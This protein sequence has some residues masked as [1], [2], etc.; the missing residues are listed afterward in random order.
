MSLLEW[1]SLGLVAV[2][3]PCFRR[4]AKLALG[5]IETKK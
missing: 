5:V 2:H 4:V 3:L 1:K